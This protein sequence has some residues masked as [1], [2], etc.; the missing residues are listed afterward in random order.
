MPFIE[1]NKGLK[2]SIKISFRCF[3]TVTVDQNQELTSNNIKRNKFYLYTV[4]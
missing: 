1:V 3:I 4:E 2:I